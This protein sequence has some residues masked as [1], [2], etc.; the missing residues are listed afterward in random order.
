[1]DILTKK[2]S[3]V[4]KRE[5]AKREAET[6]TSAINRKMITPLAGGERLG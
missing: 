2:H 1:M 4:E 6:P 3:I 5:E